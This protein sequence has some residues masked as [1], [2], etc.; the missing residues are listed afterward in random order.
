MQTER[1]AVRG[2]IDE[3][4]GK[5]CRICHS[6]LLKIT[7]ADMFIFRCDKCKIEVQPKPEDTILYESKN[8][9]NLNTYAPL[10]YKATEDPLNPKVTD[11]KCKKCGHQVIT[12]VV[13]PI[14][15]VKMNICDKCR[16][17]WAESAEDR[18]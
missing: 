4:S 8:T 6:L 3:I 2:E 11:K 18:D 5:F 1:K 7:T 16:N 17:S 15:M 12:Q 14:N 9:N 10:L 13:L